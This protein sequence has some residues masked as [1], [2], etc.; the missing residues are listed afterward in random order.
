MITEVEQIMRE[1]VTSDVVT[2]QAAYAQVKRDLDVAGRILRTARVRKDVRVQHKTAI[3]G[4]KACI[5][6]LEN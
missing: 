3:T 1:G 6:V 2:I 5:E 4:M